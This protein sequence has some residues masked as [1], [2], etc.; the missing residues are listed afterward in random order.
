[1]QHEHHKKLKI[2]AFITAFVLL[3][4]AIYYASYK[5]STTT[6]NL[7]QCREFFD[8]KDLENKKRLCCDTSH[9]NSSDSL[10]AA[11]CDTIGINPESSFCT[12]IS[13]KQDQP[14]LSAQ[15]IKPKAAK[16]PECK[17]FVIE[18]QTEKIGDQYL[19]KAG[20]SLK[21]NY[22][23]Y[24]PEIKARSYIYEFFSYDDGKNNYKAISFEPGKSYR[25]FYNASDLGKVN[26]MNQIDG[27]HEDLYK[28]DLNNDSKYPKNILMVLSIID[29]N[30]KRYLQG[31]NCF[32]KIKVDDTPNYCKNISISD[33]EISKGEVAS[34]TVTPNTPNV[35]NYD[36]R[37]VNTQNNKEISFS[38]QVISGYP[39]VNSNNSRVIVNGSGSNPAKINLSWTN[40]YKVD[41]NTNENLKNLKVTAY[42]RPREN[43]ESDKVAACS[44]ELKIKPDEGVKLCDDIKFNLYRKNSSGSYELIIPGASDTFTMKST[45][46]ISIRSQAKKKDIKEF[47]YSFHNLDNINNKDYGKGKGY[48]KEGI[49]NPYPINFKKDVDLEITKYGQEDSSDASIKVYY[50]D[51]DSIDL[52]TGTRPR[53]VQVRAMFKNSN[54][55]L[56]QLDS[57]CVKEFRIE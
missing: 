12:E 38:S 23:I 54:N 19:L 11:K 29:Q 27:L 31:W 40:L 4:G 36:F 22:N 26:Q 35:G 2:Y 3:V 15:Q 37:L 48:T 56:S 51:L 49:R 39:A 43:V 1:M 21:V 34:I 41:N 53:N 50:E 55:E 42:V 18:S 30:Q 8:N 20:Q 9:Y 33:K 6:S 57:S 5:I 13:L 28:Q 10:C 25:A 45:D 52:L 14:G 32:V 24:S 47:I 17:N 44:V 16:L 7:A 46:Y